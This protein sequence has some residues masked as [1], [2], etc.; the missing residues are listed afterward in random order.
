M[1]GD[2]ALLR[3]EKVEVTYNEVVTVLRGISFTV[4]K[5]AAVALLGANGTG[6]STT[7]KAISNLLLAENGRVRSG[8]VEFAGKRIDGI[9]PAEVVQL[10]V[11]HVME[12]RRLFPHLT[13][14]ENLRTGAFARNDRKEIGQ[15]IARMLSYF[16]R[17]KDRR[18]VQ[19]GYLSGGEQQMVALARGLMARPQLLLLDEPSMG[20]APVLVKEIFEIIRQL[21][22]AEGM[23][24]LLAEQN[25]S[26]A[27]SVVDYAYVLENGEFVLSGTAADL[28]TNNDIQKFYLGLSDIAEH[29][30][31]SMKQ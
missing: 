9:D 26:Q 31:L 13:T 5:G 16:P 10:G 21:R 3:L 8:T 24:I 11:A 2:G 15:D 22:E 1:T 20:L 30:T 19:A 12:G 4:A 27:L 28:R 6:K 25:A 14:E 23:S 17:L 29:R 7:L 18:D